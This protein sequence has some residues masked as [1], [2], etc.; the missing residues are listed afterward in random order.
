MANEKLKVQNVQWQ[1]NDAPTL[2]QVTARLNE[3]QQALRYVSENPAVWDYSIVNP[4]STAQAGS[5]A[6]TNIIDTATRDM[7]AGAVARFT[8]TIGATPTCTYALQGSNDQ[9][10]WSQL[11]TALSTTPA[12]F[13]STTFVLTTAGTIFY[14]IRPSQPFRYVRVLYSANTNVTNTA[15]LIVF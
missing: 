5:G 14:Y 7:P 1:L 13:I 9:S 10:T 11:T 8:T 4:F 6:S 3:T 2:I 15:D 12:T